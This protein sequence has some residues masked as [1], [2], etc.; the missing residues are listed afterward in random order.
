MEETIATQELEKYAAKLGVIYTIR[1]KEDKFYLL[2][3]NGYKLS[4]PVS[5]NDSLGVINLIKGAVEKD[6][7]QS[8][9]VREWKYDKTINTKGARGFSF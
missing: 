4:R 6:T 3:A 5:F 2:E 7:R 8:A 1:K 9:F